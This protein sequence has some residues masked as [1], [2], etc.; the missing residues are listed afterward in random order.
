MKKKMGCDENKPQ[1]RKN[2][3]EI[4]DIM[5]IKEFENNNL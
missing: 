4:K 2:M 3:S 1:K 5:I